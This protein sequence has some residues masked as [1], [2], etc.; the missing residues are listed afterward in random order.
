MMIRL[1]RFAAMA[2]VALAGVC[3]AGDHP[4]DSL[5][6]DMS[7]SAWHAAAARRSVDLA[8]QPSTSI[9][10]YQSTGG[11]IS[12]SFHVNRPGEESYSTVALCVPAG[13][14]LKAE[15]TPTAMVPMADAALVA[16]PIT[17]L[18][19]AAPVAVEMKSLGW[20]RGHHLA[21][22]FIPLA[23]HEAPANRIV[24]GR[25]ELSFQSLPTFIKVEAV[26][27]TAST[28]ALRRVLEAFVANPADLDRFAVD[29]RGTIAPGP[30][31]ENFDSR[32]ARFPGAAHV[33][34]V[35]VTT[36]SLV[37]ISGRDL[38][39]AGVDTAALDPSHV[40]LVLR[41]EQQPMLLL[42]ATSG[43]DE[44]T[45]PAVGWADD[46]LFLFYGRRNDSRFTLVNPYWLV[47]D[48][49]GSVLRWGLAGG[50]PSRWSEPQPGAMFESL[51][52]VEE[53]HEVLIRNDQFLSILG[54]R[55]AWKE[56]TTSAPV[57]VQFDMPGLVKGVQD[58]D[59]TLTLYVH[60]WLKDAKAPVRFRV[61][62]SS[63]QTFEV[64]AED[65]AT[66]QFRIPRDLLKEHGNVLTIALGDIQTSGGE[67]LRA[68]VFRTQVYLDKL[69]VNYPRAFRA[70]GGELEFGP[71]R[72]SISSKAQTDYQITEVTTSGRSL[73]LDMTSTSPAL[74]W[75]GKPGHTTADFAVGQMVS[76]RLI[77]ARADA[78]S[79][80]TLSS[81]RGRPDLRKAKQQADYII[82]SHSDFIAGIEPFAKAK[83][84][85]GHAVAVVD[86]RDVYDQFA[87]G[88]ETPLAI[89]AF[90]RHAADHWRGTS[91]EPA[92]SYVLLVGDATSAYRNEFRNDVVNYVPSYTVPDPANPGE[93]WASDQW[94]ATLF[95][96][97]VVPDLMLGRFSVNNVTDLKQVVAKQLA[98]AGAPNSDPWRGRLGFVADHSDFSDTVERVMR[99]SVPP[100]FDCT[101]IFLDDEPWSDN[102]YFPAE[103]AERSK[104]KVSAEATR[105]IRDMINGGVA[106]VTYFGHGSPNIW[107][108]ERIWFGGDSENS[109]NLMLTNGARLPFIVNM[110]CNSG[111]IDYPQPRW[112]V[113]IS[114]DF[115]R[116]PDGGA[117]GCFVPTG[118][119]LTRNHETFAV[120]LNHALLTDEMRP[121]GA[122]ATLA[123]L[124]YLERGGPPDLVRMYLLLGDPALDLHPV[125]GKPTNAIPADLLMERPAVAVAPRDMEIVSWKLASAAATDEELLKE[126]DVP[127]IVVRVRNPAP[128]PRREVVLS[129]LKTVGEEPVVES[130]AVNFMPGE[131]RDVEV[132]PRLLAGVNR[133]L[134][135]WRARGEAEE[136]LQSP[137]GNRI[138]ELAAVS[139]LLPGV[140][141]V[142]PDPESVTIASRQDGAQA[143]LAIGVTLYNVSDLTSPE[144]RVA[145]VGE[146]GV[147]LMETMVTLQPLFPGKS[148]RITLPLTLSP[149]PAQ[150]TLQLRLDALSSVEG[151]DEWPRMSVKVGRDAQPDLQVMG[152]GVR[153][154]PA[155]P[156]DGETIVFDV[157][158]RNSGARR[159]RGARLE[160]YDVT[161]TVPIKMESRVPGSGKLFTLDAG[162]ITTVTLRWDPFR[163]AGL[164]RVEFRAVPV[165]DDAERSP[166]DN[167]LQR[168]VRVRTKHNLTPLGIHALPFDDE[169]RRLRRVR[170][171]ATV[172]NTG[173]S[174]A[175]GVKVAFYTSAQP[176]PDAL[177]GETMIDEIP[178]GQSRDALMEYKIKQG[179]ENKPVAFSYQVFLKGSA[180]RVASP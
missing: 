156:A 168:E 31:L 18:Q 106:M 26:D 72:I 80:V 135:K 34:R 88:E 169:D 144:M 165:A 150:R 92:A 40:K 62:G 123:A 23:M 140:Q 49:T 89:K 174:A 79:T 52:T 22:V 127:V 47:V 71:P 77:L 12:F 103:V 137:Q 82:I 24:E 51:L 29:D 161:T 43:W 160:A 170:M 78:A 107:S 98:F 104:A 7:E 180:Q 96:D 59:S 155:S 86:V 151:S 73:V 134:L 102:F 177:L 105:R 148:Q 74:V 163:N 69:E 81:V 139:K 167:V 15:L 149:V 21:Q 100:Q 153:M 162:E 125:N 48:A 17:P 1:R 120:Q 111:A 45:T 36:N 175:R 116:T 114:E 112:N 2:M 20:M 3:A 94:Y 145:L 84:D 118:P 53:D 60:N 90:L 68:G 101:G 57:E 39:E 147:N 8:A 159:S 61:N 121:V 85:Q 97:D 166:A 138:I 131:E 99:D 130:A 10:D 63:P 50:A 110:T 32:A 179:E 129:L 54:F 11:R 65:D 14:F 87:E 19:G 6:R 76:T 58:A 27:D 33:M 124:R 157:P 132:R 142:Q 173:E 5:P 75:L 133:F 64:S 38:R 41:G 55:W 42:R 25:V 35:P 152:E 122:A 46:D 9:S 30:G 146:D 66:H 176:N 141:A 16:P 93:H 70:V 143:T 171:V 164:R 128:S 119:G 117:V 154:E 115:M 83:R 67:P 108:S 158:V 136:V 28:G 113:C 4:L 44:S 95:G 91:S 37:Q 56:L 109:D 126:G 172:S 178:A 13:G